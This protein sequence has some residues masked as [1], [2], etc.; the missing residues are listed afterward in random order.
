MTTSRVILVDD[1]ALV[2]AGIRALLEG[3]P[4]VAVTGEAADGRTALE[5]VKTQA[6]DVVLLDISMAKLGGLEALPR[7]VHDFP[8]VKVI[9]LSGHSNEEF[10]LRA[11]RSGAVGYLLKDSVAEELGMAIKAV[12]AGNTYLS[13]PVSR[14]VVEGYLERSRPDATP[15]DL[16]TPRQRE[17]LQLVA[18]GANTKE[19]AYVL[20]ISVKTVEAHRAQLMD[21]LGIFEVAGLVRYAIRTG[22]ASAE[23]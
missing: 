2:R 20:K 7:I 13:P 8:A 22:L 4:G 3:L 12:M 10:V 9:I 16:L 14:A 23:K 19:I 21:R 1:H 6:P 17:I 18:E 5:L 11:L 15:A